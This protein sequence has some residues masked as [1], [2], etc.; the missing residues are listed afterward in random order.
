M[1]KYS[2]LIGTIVG[3]LFGIGAAM[4]FLPAEIIAQQ[5]EIIAALGTLGSAIGTFFAPKNTPPSV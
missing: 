5:P 4:G 3:A 2:K 1:G